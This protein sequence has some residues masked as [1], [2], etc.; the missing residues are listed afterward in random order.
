MNEIPTCIK[1]SKE[2]AGKVSIGDKV[3]IK[4]QGIVTGVNERT[5][6]GMVEVNSKPKKEK[7]YEIELK[8][9]SV[10]EILENKADKALKEMTRK[11]E[12]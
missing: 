4:V 7:Y 2:Q 6:Y 8:E 9:S 10:S 1:V 12:K 11:G 3:S 5:N